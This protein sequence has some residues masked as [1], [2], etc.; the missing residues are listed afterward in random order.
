[1]SESDT[2]TDILSVRRLIDQGLQNSDSDEVR[3]VKRRVAY[4]LLDMIEKNPDVDILNSVFST[5]HVEILDEDMLKIGKIDGKLLVLN[6]IPFDVQIRLD[7]IIRNAMLERKSDVIRLLMNASVD[8]FSIEPRIMIMCA[9]QGLD[10]LFLEMVEKKVPIYTENY[11]CLYYLAEKGKLDLL[12]VIMQNYTFPSIAEIAGKITVQAIIHNQV[13]ILKHFCPLEGF[14]GAPDIV[15]T[16]FKKA[17]E[18]GGHLSVIRYFIK[19][20]VDIK[21][22]NYIAVRIACQCNRIEI[23]K[24]FY[25]IDNNMLDV[26]TQEEKEN[27]GFFK[28]ILMDQ[29]LGNQAFCHIYYDDIKK[30]DR[31][32]QCSKKL[33]CFKESSWKEWVNMK[34]EWVCPIC[35]SD[36]KR[37]LY[38]N[39]GKNF[40]SVS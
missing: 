40:E 5:G 39:K 26:L 35:F 28:L 38:V 11:R 24:Y 19:G 33:H 25:E 29:Y 15:F 1:M 13:P 22:E 16:F 14:T 9:T 31:Y 34:T 6:V 30:N 8:L 7:Q 23:L 18:H 12:K 10:D 17:I 4:K 27:F 32:F 2:H 37:I 21:Q 20:G 3:S 36:V